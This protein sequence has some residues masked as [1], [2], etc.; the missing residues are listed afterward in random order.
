MQKTVL[1]GREVLPGRVIRDHLHVEGTALEV[2]YV[3]LCG[4]TEGP[5]AIVTAGIHNAEFIG[6]QAAI[7]LSC[8]LDPKELH[9]NVAIVPLCNR[10]GFENRTMSRVCED[11]TALPVRLPSS[12][13]KTN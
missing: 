5:T 9:G 6:I 2:P 4:D 7:E 12:I 10:S 8:E 11:G 1:A 3:I 13:R